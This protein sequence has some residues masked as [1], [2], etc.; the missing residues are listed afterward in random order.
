MQR[1]FFCARSSELPILVAKGT[2][3]GQIEA[4]SINL[5]YMRYSQTACVLV[6]IDT[7]RARYYN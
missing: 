1:M 5:L 7:V 3:I 6:S 2:L 4:Y